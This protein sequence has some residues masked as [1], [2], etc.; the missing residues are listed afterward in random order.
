MVKI[1]ITFHIDPELIEQIKAVDPDLEILYDPSLLGK[2]RYMNDQHGGLIERTPEQNEK[3]ESM[4]A[5]AEIVFGY[6]PR[7]YYGAIEKRFPRLRWMQS[8]SAGIGWGAKL[9][10]W[11]ETD[12]LFTTSS[13]IHATPLAEFC[14][15]AMLMYAK[16]YFYMEQGKRNHHWQ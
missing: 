7:G 1:L 3:L 16:D 5:E 14:L 8:P 15:M 6:V 13:G 2:P 12:I 10:G 9:R 11:T 4:M